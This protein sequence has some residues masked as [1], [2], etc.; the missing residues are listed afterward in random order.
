MKFLID[1][2]LPR[3]LVVRLNEPNL[4]AIVVAFQTSSLVE[5]TQTALIV[6]G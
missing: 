3:R 1:A 2:Q 6:H 5:L 4:P